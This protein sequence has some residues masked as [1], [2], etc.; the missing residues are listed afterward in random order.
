MQEGAGLRRAPCAVWRLQG[1]GERRG[2]AR[3]GRDGGSA[4][5]ADVAACVTCAGWDADA[6]R[7]VRKGT[8]RAG[9]PF[10]CPCGRVPHGP[11]HRHPRCAPLPRPQ[12]MKS[13]HASHTC[14]ASQTQRL[15]L[16]C[17]RAARA[18]E[19]RPLHTG[20]HAPAATPT[21]HPHPATS[22]NGS[23]R[24]CHAAAAQPPRDK[25]PRPLGLLARLPT[26]FSP[27]QP[28][29]PPNSSHPSSPDRPPATPVRRVEGLWLCAGV[30]A[31]RALGI[32]ASL[33]SS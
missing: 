27:P 16:R 12:D 20:R 3:C 32:A 10:A 17:A 13:P 1:A 26:R 25:R 15:L 28:P 6:A 4:W 8:R 7:L 31:S 22:T 23:N 5:P 18:S 14:R 33:H 21:P 2:H 29:L 19:A 9:R 11:S 24:S 30:P